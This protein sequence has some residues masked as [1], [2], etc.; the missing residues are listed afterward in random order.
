MQIRGST[1]GF[2]ERLCSMSG[3]SPRE[4]DSEEQHKAR[5]ITG[6]TGVA[7]AVLVFMAVLAFVQHTPVLGC[8]DGGVALLLWL[9]VLFLRKTGRAHAASHIGLS[10]LGIFLLLLFI[11]GGRGGT[12]HL[13]CYGFPPVAFFL[14]GSRR[15]VLAVSLLLA[16]LLVLIAAGSGASVPA[17][18]SRDFAVGFILSLGVAS[19]FSFMGVR[20]RERTE[21]DLARQRDT[22]RSVAEDLRQA[23][24]AFRQSEARFRE[25]AELLPSIVCEV[26]LDRRFRY[27]NQLWYETMGFTP[28]DVGGGMTL[29]DML[30]PEEHT[31]AEARFAQMLEG[32]QLDVTEYR[33]C[34][35]DGSPV[36]LLVRTAPMTRDG[37]LIGVRA[38]ATNVT[39]LNRLRYRVEEVR[40]LE[41]IGTL[42]GGIAHEFNNSLMAITGSAEL[43]QKRLPGDE[44]AAVCLDRISRASGHMAELTRQL[45]AY[46]R[47]GGMQVEF[48]NAGTLLA[49]TLTLLQHSIPPRVRVETAIGTDGLRISVDR[50]Q[51][52]MALSAVLVNAVEAIEGEGCIRVTLNRVV[53]DSRQAA[54]QDLPRQGVYVRLRVADSGRGMDAETLGRIFEPFHTTKFQG[55]GLGMATVYSI[56]KNHGGA[57]E[58]ASKPGIGS[59]VTVCLPAVE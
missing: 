17:S 34:R 19:V 40:K 54:A 15:G 5:L 10:I 45:L 53:Y 13:W 57:V 50:M 12:G 51:L 2:I 14:L 9:N 26:G 39:E 6:S 25:T 7:V 23:E 59:S 55:R 31:K 4:G 1:R 18:G 29:L 8:V 38:S 56:V 21:R 16:G 46:A 32:K 27:V 48:L 47:G 41:A 36:D 49:R 33:A 11:S 58:V 52:Q 43:L 24:Q 22:A 44:R 35:K 42:A 3:C 28:E 30:P 20:I 37:Q